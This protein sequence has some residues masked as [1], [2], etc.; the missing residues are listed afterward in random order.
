MRL[1]LPSVVI[2]PRRSE[3]RKTGY[4]DYEKLLANL[5]CELSRTQG[6]AGSIPTRGTEIWVFL[7]L[8]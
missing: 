3:E 1:Q 2:V 7:I 6:V 5:S 8:P 4:G